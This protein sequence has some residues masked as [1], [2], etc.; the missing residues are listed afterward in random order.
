MCFDYTAFVVRWH[1]VNRFNHTSLLI[2]V[3]P[4]DRLK[5]VSNHCVI[6]VFGSVFVLSL[7]FSVILCF[8]LG[9]LP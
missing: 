8:G 6:E 1:P 9:F 4:T 7:Y 3:T 5:S 2:E